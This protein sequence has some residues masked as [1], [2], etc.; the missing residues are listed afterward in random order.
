V[1]GALL[2]VNWIA[3]LLLAT[4]DCLLPAA[5]KG[6]RAGGTLRPHSSLG[7][8]V[9]SRGKEETVVTLKM[10]QQRANVIENKG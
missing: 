3:F 1:T 9:F 4:G 6:V 10:T 5:L 2:I 7:Q 8:N